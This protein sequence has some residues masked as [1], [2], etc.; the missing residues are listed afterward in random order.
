M[1]HVRQAEQRTDLAD[2]V[3][4]HGD[5]D[6]AAGPAHQVGGQRV[7]QREQTQPRRA[8]R[9]QHARDAEQGDADR[10]GVQDRKRHQPAVLLAA[11]GGAGDQMAGH[12]KAEHR[13]KVEEQPCEHEGDAAQKDARRET[14]TAALGR[15]GVADFGAIDRVPGWFGRGVVRGFVGCVVRCGGRRSSGWAQC[16]EDGDGA[17][18]GKA[19]CELDRQAT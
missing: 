14:I 3:A 7:R 18:D 12:E 17:A 6:E 1:R 15:F 10:I 19:Q 9:Q 5:D 4:E 16:F 13:N 2:C 8:G 11:D